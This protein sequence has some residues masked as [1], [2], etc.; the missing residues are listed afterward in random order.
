L[1]S[2]RVP[3]AVIGGNAVAAWVATIDAGAVRNTQDVDILLRRAD[4]SAARAALES[5]GF[6]Y[7]HAAGIEMFLDGP[8]AK[9]RDAVHIVFS[10]EKVRPEY[11]E[12]APE[13][14]SSPVD[15]NVRVLPLDALVRMKLTSFRD[16]D[17][18]HLRDMIEVGLIDESWCARLPPELADRFQQLLATPEG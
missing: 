18:T 1:E 4:L 7:R 2:A 13:V 8:N 3:Y 5:A 17:R 16:K 15:R 11:C 9:A 12:A 6:S 10:A 14:D